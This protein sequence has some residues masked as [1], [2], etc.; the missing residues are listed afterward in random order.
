M[1]FLQR[2]LFLATAILPDLE[3]SDVEM[4]LPHC[5]PLPIACLL[6]KHTIPNPYAQVCG[7]QVC[8]FV[9]TPANT[10]VVWGMC[11]TFSEEAFVGAPPWHGLKLL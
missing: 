5:I 2:I 11:S 1:Y 4:R 3:A 10:A 7:A 6:A 9:H 8:V